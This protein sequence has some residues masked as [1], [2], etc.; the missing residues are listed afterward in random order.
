MNILDGSTEAW[1]EMFD[2][3]VIALS[4]CAR[5]ALK[6]MKKKKAD[7]GIIINI[8]RFVNDNTTDTNQ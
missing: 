2:V 3:N 6:S 1:K 4:V 7:D 8:N 5:E